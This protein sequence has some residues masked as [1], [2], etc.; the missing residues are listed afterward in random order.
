M[1]S[2]AINQTCVC[3][4][5]AS[6]LTNQH[7]PAP[8]ARMRQGVYPWLEACPTRWLCQDCSRK[9]D[10]GYAAAGLTCGCG[11]WVKGRGKW[12]H[13]AQPA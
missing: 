10:V 7:Y 3:G 6:V 9:G 4:R 8:A 5:P 1:T 11:Y 12:S 2:T 13:A